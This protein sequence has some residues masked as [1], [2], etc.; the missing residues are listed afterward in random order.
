MTQPETQNIETEYG[1]A[2]IETYDC[3][4]CGNTVA[5]ENTVKFTIGETEGRAC[6]Y[7]EKNGPISFPKRALEFAW[8]SDGVF[9]LGWNIALAF[10]IL[11]VAV[12]YGFTDDA[13]D[14]VEGYATAVISILVWVGIPALL[15]V[16][17]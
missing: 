6:E 9:G 1:T 14:F 12:F 13:T 7:C 17:Q 8:P 4:S 11:P 15:W 5:Y 10:L 16:I 3:D 2:T